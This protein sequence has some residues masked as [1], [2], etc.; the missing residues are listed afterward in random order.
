[1][2]HRPRPLSPHLQVYRWQVQMVVSILT[3]ATGIIAGLAAFL[4]T[5]GLVALAAGDAAWLEFVELVR[6]PLGFIVLFVWTWALAFHSF[7]G[8][9]H[10]AQDAGVGMKIESV[11]RSSWATIIGS[12]L[13]TALVWVIAM[14]QEGG[15]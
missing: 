14:M 11:I 4:F 1:M 8:I 12:L 3:R 7:A 13:V 2:A 9:R 15:A 6:S 10:L 5:A